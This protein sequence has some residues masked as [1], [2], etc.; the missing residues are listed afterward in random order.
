MKLSDGFVF[1]LAGIGAVKVGAWVS[2][3]MATALVRF[4]NWEPTAAKETAPLILLA[5]AAGVFIMG[6]EVKA[7]RINNAGLGY[8]P[9]SKQRL[10]K[11][12][13]DGRSV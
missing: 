3:C 2:N 12:A 9:N 11:E 4:G 10:S 8:I 6:L 1:A 13:H 7:E 5:L